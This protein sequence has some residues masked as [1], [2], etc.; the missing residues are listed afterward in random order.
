M[1]ALPANPDTTFAP[2]PLSD[3]TLF[4]WVAVL[5]IAGMA[6]VGVV[7]LL[8]QP[9]VV[10]RDSSQFTQALRIWIGQITAKRETARSLKQFINRLR[11]FAMRMRTEEPEPTYWD[12][13]LWSTGLWHRPSATPPTDFKEADLVQWSVLYEV[14]PAALDDESGV[15]IEI[16]ELMKAHAKQFERNSEKRDEERNQFRELTNGFR[17]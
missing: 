10:V 7:G 13:L 17:N 1:P 14:C 11:Y 3:S 5:G 8:R 15:P 12:R 2:A 9:D 16:A 4:F 6:A